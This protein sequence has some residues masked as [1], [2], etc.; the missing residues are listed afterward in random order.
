VDRYRRPISAAVG[1]LRARFPALRPWLPAGV[2]IVL[3]VFVA[4]FIGE[5]RQQRHR[6]DLLADFS[7]ESRELGLRLQD[8]MI[9]YRQVLRGARS[10]FSS[11]GFLSKDEWAQYVSNLY[12]GIDFPG[13]RGI[14]YVSKVPP[15]KQAA[16][17]ER[18]QANGYPLYRVWPQGPD[19]QRMPIVR[20]APASDVNDP[21]IGL[22][23]GASAG[24]R[25]ALEQSAVNA[26][27][28]MSPPSSLL[29]QASADPATAHAD[30]IFFF[31][32]I[33]DPTRLMA[34]AGAG[35]ADRR[36]ALTGWV[37][38]LFQPS[39]LVSA[40]LGPLPR[41][42]TL[43]VYSGDRQTADRLIHDSTAGQPVSWQGAV[44][45]RV[46]MPLLLDGQRWTLVFEGFPRAYANQTAFNGEWL[47]ILMICLLFSLSVLLMTRARA[48]AVRLHNLSLELLASNERYQFL[49]THDALTRV[50]NRFLFQERLA[51]TLAQA[52]RYGRPF[53]LIYIDL[54]HFKP[55]NDQLGH[56]IG[57]LLLLDVTRRLQS[58]LRDTDLLARRGGDEFVVLLPEVESIRDAERL[59]DR[60]CAAL[61]QPFELEG[62][63]VAISGS[64]GL[65]TFPHD[66]VQAETLVNAADHRM[67]LAKQQGRNRWVSQGIE[68]IEV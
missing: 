40:T 22:D 68:S 12:L 20:L 38:G 5:T 45:L 18:M 32:P 57:D 7:F 51:S 8:R 42:M 29:T 41:N 28:R 67:Y 56:H 33:Y 19:D 63:P 10:V 47:A 11:V 26:Q 54:D 52:S 3:S 30:H 16:H 4:V 60:I 34:S 59:A 65:A 27:A 37:F 46:V 36:L 48:S 14:G 31:Q 44:P 66:G 35:E 55:V 15:D 13:I 24:L 21:L 58:L 43:R 49:A 1:R 17:I 2:A 53:A 39:A 61:A 62:H 50:A 64:L 23:L 9:A 6:H 25:E